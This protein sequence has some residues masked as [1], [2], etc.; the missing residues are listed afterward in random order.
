MILGCRIA[1]WTPLVGTIW[2]G[3][4]RRNVH[5]LSSWNVNMFI[6]A[7]LT[8]S[9]SVIVDVF[10]LLGLFWARIHL[11]MAGLLTMNFVQ[12]SS[13][14][15]SFVQD[16]IYALGKAHIH[17]TPSLRSF[18]NVAFESVLMFVWLTMAPS[19]F[20]GR[21]SSGFL[22][23]RLSPA[24]DRY[25]AW[26]GLVVWLVLIRTGLC[27]YSLLVH[28]FVVP[29]DE[30]RGDWFLGCIYH[31]VIAQFRIPLWSDLF[32][33][34]DQRFADRSDLRNLIKRFKTLQLC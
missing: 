5:C 34:W 29:K 25:M 9:V 1:A 13:V 21:S 31:S 28:Y 3:R 4:E 16:S 12:F 24:C 2:Y 26:I 7:I 19:S 20:Q 30:K 23:L 32:S 8:E 11:W 33:F 10:D 14:R 22:S 15:F 17:S 6:Q 18:P 27:R